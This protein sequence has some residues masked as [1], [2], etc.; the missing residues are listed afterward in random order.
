M[1]AH[2]TNSQFNPRELFGWYGE[3]NYA[4]ELVDS[5]ACWRFRVDYSCLHFS[6]L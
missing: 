2:L 1:H 5:L 6:I 3:E 4:S